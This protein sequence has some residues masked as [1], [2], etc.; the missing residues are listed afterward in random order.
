MSFHIHRLGV[1]TL[2][3]STTRRVIVVAVAAVVAL[4]GLQPQTLYSQQTRSVADGVYAADQATRG[5]ALYKD[6]CVS[7]HGDALKGDLAPPLAGGDFVAGWS[8]Q[9]LSELVTKVQKTMPADDPGTLSAAQTADLVALILKSNA[10]PAGSTPLSS[11][12]A[13][14]KNIVWPSGNAAAP[15]RT[16]A[17]AAMGAD[18]RPM[19]N[20]A[21][22]MKGI[23]FP[24]SNLI[25]NVQSTDPG[26]QK[27]G[28][29]PANTGFSWVDWGAG[30]Y[31]GWD[32]IDD[33]AIS[34]AETAPLLLTPGRRCENGKPVPVD[35]DDWVKYTIEL[36]EA[37]RAAFKASQSRN[38][39]AVSA[40]TDQLATACLNC[41]VVYRDKPGGS[42]KDPSNKAVRC[43]P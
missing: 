10:L 42:A 32:L 30:I 29:K 27:V 18:T 23:F 35:R 38:Q 43:T 19:G 3:S 15:K 14:L 24:S 36:V 17:P 25:F 41:H 6:R 33:A 2:A 21:Q 12:M 8:R 5:Q 16:A 4:A 34:I 13:A 28:W 31:P 7:C 1:R 9:P 39:E 11:D 26:T 40:V 20:L 22:L 37:G